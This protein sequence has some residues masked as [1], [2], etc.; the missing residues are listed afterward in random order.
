MKRLKPMVG[1]DGVSHV[2]TRLRV[3]KE[4]LGAIYGDMNVVQQFMHRTYVELENGKTAY[5]FLFDRQAGKTAFP[6]EKLLHS[7]D[8][9]APAFVALRIA[10]V[11]KDANG[12]MKIA[13]ARPFSYVVP[14]IFDGAASATGFTEAECLLGVFNGS[15]ISM[16]VDQTE[17][18][19]QWD[20]SMFEYIPETQFLAGDNLL[21]STG[22]LSEHEGWVDMGKEV[23]IFGGNQ[24]HV[25][26]E[27]RD[28]DVS[29]IQSGVGE[30]DNE[31][32]ILQ[33]WSFGY[34]IRGGSEKLRHSDMQYRQL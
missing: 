15:N 8:A 28:A 18:I 12:K 33:L 5:E 24:N 6:S 1:V 32:N 13:N 4:K 22:S 23:V 25:K 19:Y 3:L 21:P 7:N 31:V 20:G 27:F 17:I 11:K 2:T 30:E 34:I 16:G 10:K 29:S 9:F 26:L 14:E